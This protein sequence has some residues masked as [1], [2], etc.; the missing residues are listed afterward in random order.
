[1]NEANTTGETMQKED[2]RSQSSFCVPT[3]QASKKMN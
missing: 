2:W 1:M 3:E